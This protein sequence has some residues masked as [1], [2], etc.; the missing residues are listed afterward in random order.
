MVISVPGEYYVYE[1]E[2]LPDKESLKEFFKELNENDVLELRIRSSEESEYKVY[3]ISKI[4][5]Q[6][7]LDFFA[8]SLEKA[9]NTFEQMARIAPYEVPI[10]VLD[11][12]GNCVSILK[13]IVSYYEH[14]Y[15]YEGELDLFFLNRYDSI[16]LEG[17]NEY[18]VEIYKKYC[19]AGR[20]KKSFWS[21]RNGTTMLN[22]SPQFQGLPSRSLIVLSSWRKYMYHLMKPHFLQQ[23]FRPAAQT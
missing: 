3:H 17:I 23:T 8:L 4:I 13:K 7:N 18:S 16:V 12:E 6:L 11:T 14:F 22:Y 21:V 15:R 20:E 9:E 1:T 2:Q 10:P 5:L 19:R